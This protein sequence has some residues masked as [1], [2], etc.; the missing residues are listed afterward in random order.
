MY[1]IKLDVNDTIYDK[2]MFFL[3]NIP[4]SNLE[5]EKYVNDSQPKENDIVSFFQNSPLKDNIELLRDKEFYDERVS[6]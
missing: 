2:V 4:I 1:T 5:V 6:F 3:K